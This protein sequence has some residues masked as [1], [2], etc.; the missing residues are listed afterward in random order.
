MEAIL[1]KMQR[2]AEG[3]YLELVFRMVEGD[4][5]VS[6]REIRSVLA[7]AEF[8]MERLRSDVNA[9]RYR[10][11][12]AETY[13]EAIDEEREAAEMCKTLRERN[14]EAEKL[15]REY[16]SRMFE[17]GAEID[18]LETAKDAVVYRANQ[19]K[20]RANFEL[21]RTAAKDLH[22]QMESLRRHRTSLLDQKRRLLNKLNGKTFS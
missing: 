22:K 4:E 13:H 16:R 6:E 19:N 5:G 14:A 9:L 17:I 20:A 3:K 11:E 7:A 1:A 18:R 2:D 8:T 15:T 12:Q 21:N 10:K